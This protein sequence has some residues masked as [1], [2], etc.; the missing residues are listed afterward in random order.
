MFRQ[1]LLT[2]IKLTS[3]VLSQSRG[4]ER[5]GEEDRGPEP[6][7]PLVSDEAGDGQRDSDHQGCTLASDPGHSRTDGLSVT[8]ESSLTERRSG[9][10]QEEAA[11]TD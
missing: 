10:S 6:H 1:Y 11:E 9:L 4:H 5:E 7:G 2:D 3:V 8:Q